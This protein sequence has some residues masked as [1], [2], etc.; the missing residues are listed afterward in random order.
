[1]CVNKDRKVLSIIRD[2]NETLR[3][4]PSFW[5][6]KDSALCGTLAKAKHHKSVTALLSPV[7]TNL[8]LLALAT[9]SCSNT[10]TGLLPWFGI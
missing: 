3:N 2:L 6:L 9:I 1:M 8:S 5:V 4:Q 7:P 10:N